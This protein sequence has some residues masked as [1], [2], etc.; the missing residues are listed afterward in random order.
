MKP[1]GDPENQLTQKSELPPTEGEYAP[2]GIVRSVSGLKT[3]VVFDCYS[4]V[5][6]D[7]LWETPKK[8]PAN[9]SV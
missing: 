2:L 4:T 1:S 9:L 8:H 7:N 6:Y 5:S 3:R